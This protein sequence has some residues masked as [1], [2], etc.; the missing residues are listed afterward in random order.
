M[1]SLCSSLLVQW[2]CHN[3]GYAV[4]LCASSKSTKEGPGLLNALFVFHK[5][6]AGELLHII[7][8]QAPYVYCL[9]ARKLLIL[10]R[11]QHINNC[12]YFNLHGNCIL[13]SHQVPVAKKHYNL[14]IRSY[15]PDQ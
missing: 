4:I 12:E 8:M 6:S 1:S 11:L 15:F 2:H 3:Y 5:V 13:T 7:V 14:Y 10:T 9:L